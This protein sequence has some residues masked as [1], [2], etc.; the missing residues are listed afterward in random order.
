MDRSIALIGLSGVG[1][2]TIARLLAEQLDWRWADID[3]LVVEMAGRSIAEIFVTEGESRF[4][5]YEATALR[6]V[7]QLMT[8]PCVI[9]TG[10]GIVLRAENRQLLRERSLV[11]WLDAPNQTLLARLR[12]SDEERPLLNGEHPVVRL[13]ALRTARAPLYRDLA[14]LVI[15][16]D[17]LLPVQVAALI[18]DALGSAD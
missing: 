2:S 10:G 12:T 11:V 16:T 7:L 3:A 18:I 9:A 13:E 8:T 4:R 1:K 5:K 17:G 15:A 14:N 6:G